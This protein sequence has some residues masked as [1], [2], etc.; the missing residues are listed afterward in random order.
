MMRPNLIPASEFDSR[1]EAVRCA[2]VSRELDAGVITSPENIF[3][4]TGLDHQGY[5]GPHAL[6]VPREGDAQLFA[7]AHERTTGE[8]QVTNARFVGYS[9]TASPGAF[10]AEYLKAAGLGDASLGVQGES[11]GFPPAFDAAMRAGLPEAR[12]TDISGLVEQLR[13][14]KSEN[15]IVAIRRAAEVADA[16]M[17]TALAVANVGVNEQT[18]AAEVHRRMFEMG[19]DYVGFGPF[20]RS[21][22]RL[23]Y[24]HEVWTDRVIGEG[25]HL[26]L[27]MAGCVGRYHAPM[28]RLAF[29]GHAPDGTSDVAEICIAAQERVLE[30]MRPGATGAAAYNAW[31]SVVDD[32]GLSHYRRHHCGYNIGIAFPPT[33]TG[34]IGVVSMHPESDMVLERNMV[35]HQ[36]SWLLGCGRGDYFVSDTVRVGDNGGERLTTAPRDVAVL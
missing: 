7:R 31:Q 17:E 10:I 22:D 15:E 25:E 18:V 35:F 4:V 16:I 23:P 34:G 32:A 13:L 12:W 3:Y 20:I 28:G 19:G 9:D 24:E 6:I 21:G 30:A 11:L 5:F 1:M 27:E 29:A 33:W 36:L 26:I 8:R 14:V 2:L